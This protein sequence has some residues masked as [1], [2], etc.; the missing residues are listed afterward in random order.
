MNPNLPP[1][2]G[3]VHQIAIWISPAI[4]PVMNNDTISEYTWGL[5]SKCIKAYAP[6]FAAGALIPAEQQAYDEAE[7]WYINY[8]RMILSR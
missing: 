2:P 1:I 5:S 3:D 7:E 8:Q 6:G 4:T